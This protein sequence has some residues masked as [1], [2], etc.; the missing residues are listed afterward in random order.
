MLQC[1][2][3]TETPVAEVLVALL[4]LRGG[5]GDPRD[6]MVGDCFLLCE[7]GEHD[8][9]VEHAAHLW[10]AEPH[11]GRDLWFLWA[12]A[13]AHRVYRFATLPP[14]PAVL[15]D[16]GTGAVE[17]CLFFARHRPHA[18]SFSV[19]DPLADLIAPTPDD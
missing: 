6:A 3:V 19:A 2:A 12:G 10:T 14:C 13:G 16:F 18:H 8:E 11:G 7:L 9:S 17:P 1:T 4:D 5:P 15:R